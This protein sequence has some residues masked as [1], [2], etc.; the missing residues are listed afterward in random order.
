MTEA[1]FNELVNEVFERIEMALEEAGSDADCDNSGGVMIV[2]FENDTTMV[3]SR[4]LATQQLWLAARS[5]GYHFEYEANISDW[6][7]TRSGDL[8]SK[9]LKDE[10][11][12]QADTD[13]ESF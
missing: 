10:L 5:G 11:K 8:F 3:F 13:I 9:K 12:S 1:E 2:E 6:R 7:C 4:Q